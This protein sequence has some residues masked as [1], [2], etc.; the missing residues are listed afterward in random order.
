MALH[1]WWTAF[2]SE[3][4]EIRDLTPVLARELASLAA[5][6]ALPGIMLIGLRQSA[7]K[8]YAGVALD[9]DVERPQDLAHPIKAVEPIAVLFRFDDNPPTVLSFVT[10]FPTRRIR[11][12]RRPATLARSVSTTGPGLK[13]ACP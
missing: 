4:S 7:D 6:H 12:G 3:L 9:V 10:T 11:T 2:G 13:P 8:G 1:A 5:A